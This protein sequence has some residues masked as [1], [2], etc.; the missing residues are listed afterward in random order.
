[1]AFMGAT[2]EYRPAEYDCLT[3]NGPQGMV[4]L[5]L[6]EQD[7]RQTAWRKL[8]RPECK[9]FIAGKA[10]FE[11]ARGSLFIQLLGSR[12]RDGMIL[13]ALGKPTRLGSGSGS[14]PDYPP[15]RSQTAIGVC[16]W[17]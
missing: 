5:Q 6:N 1:M 11:M 4:Q 7:L 9:S 16:D 12:W 14:I 15:A 13:A 8:P 17:K 3:S 10:R 2:V